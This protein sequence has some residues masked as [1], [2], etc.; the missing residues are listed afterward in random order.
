M[1]NELEKL[2]MQDITKGV[3]PTKERCNLESPEFCEMVKKLQEKNL[4][5]GVKFEISDEGNIAQPIFKSAEV[6]ALGK[7]ALG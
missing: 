4:I 5:A 6:T 1:L 2:I 3:T 7:D